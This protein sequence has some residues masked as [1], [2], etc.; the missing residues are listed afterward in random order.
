MASLFFVRRFLCI[1][2]IAAS[3]AG[4]DRLGMIMFLFLRLLALA[5]AADFGERTCFV[6]FGCGGG[7]SIR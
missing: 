3:S 7:E 6:T 4:R 5:T 2:L 1:S